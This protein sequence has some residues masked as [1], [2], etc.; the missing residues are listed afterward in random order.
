M[1]HSCGEMQNEESFTVEDCEG[2]GLG[3]EEGE[4][5]ES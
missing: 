2:K 4:G 1:K 5:K 3:K